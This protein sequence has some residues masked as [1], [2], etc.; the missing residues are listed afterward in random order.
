MGDRYQRLRDRARQPSL[1][2]TGTPPDRVAGGMGVVPAAPSTDRRP[3][4]PPAARIKPKD[5][6]RL[7]QAE[8]LQALT[9]LSES[10]TQLAA[11]VRAL[12][13]NGVLDVFYD[14]FGADGYLYRTYPVPVGSIAVVNHGAA[15]VTYTSEAPTTGAPYRGR[16]TQKIEGKSALT[17]PVA[18]R[19]FTLWGTAG[20]AVSVQVFVSLQP[21]AAAQVLT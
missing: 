5:A 10:S 15:A 2:P 14:V 18:G 13:P 11:T 3:P 20:E 19:A 9:A 12:T 8:L 1:Q 7:M 17:I 16:G 6:E 4:A 21:F